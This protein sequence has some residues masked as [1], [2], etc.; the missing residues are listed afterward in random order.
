MF[1]TT[2]FNVYKNREEPLGALSSSESSCNLFWLEHFPALFLVTKTPLLDL[3]RSDNN[4]WFYL[5][6]MFSIL[7]ITRGIIIIINQL[8]IS[9][10]EIL[11]K[12]FLVEFLFLSLPWPQQYPTYLGLCHK[13][14]FCCCCCFGWWQKPFK[15]ILLLFFFKKTS[16]VRG[17]KY[18]LRS[19]IIIAISS[20]PQPVLMLNILSRLTETLVVHSFHSRLVVP[21]T[22]LFSTATA[23][24][25]Q[26]Q[27]HSRNPTNTSGW[28]ENIEN[29]IM[30]VAALSLYLYTPDYYSTWSTIINIILRFHSLP[31]VSSLLSYSSPSSPTQRRVL[32]ATGRELSFKLHPT[33]HQR[34]IVVGRSTRRVALFL[35]PSE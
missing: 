28:R 27:P 11:L 32:M 25:Q 24:P 5:L 15:N 23:A 29:P 21:K 9:L 22:L 26:P 17:K 3:S 33:N 13:F 10:L 16:R 6:I 7:F 19:P 8:K 4:F 30:I 31:T 18:Y 1:F 2:M 34:S 20:T 12:I 14:S 35:P